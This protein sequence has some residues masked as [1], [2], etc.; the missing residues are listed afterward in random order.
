MKLQINKK[1]RQDMKRFKL[2]FQK[3][4][5]KIPIHFII[6]H[7]EGCGLLSYDM[8]E[9]LKLTKDHNFYFMGL[10]GGD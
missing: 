6:Q 10:I 9:K 4:I 5:F 3:D 1:T 8:L 7:Y 2:D